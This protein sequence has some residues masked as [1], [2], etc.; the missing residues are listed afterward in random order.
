VLASKRCW[1]AKD[2]GLAIKVWQLEAT[3]CL[4]L[5]PQKN[6]LLKNDKGRASYKQQRIMLIILTLHSAAF[7]L[8]A[9]DAQGCTE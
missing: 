9:K 2:V 5:P 8:Q 7:C 6:V 1:Y 3:L 4:L